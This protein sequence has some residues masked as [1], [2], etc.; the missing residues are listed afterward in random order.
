MDIDI[1]IP[2][3]NSKKTIKKTLHSIAS[4][5]II[6]KFHVYLVND[7]GSETYQE[8]I[9]FFRNMFDIVELMLPFN[10]GPGVARQYGI[11]HSDSKYIVF[12]DSDDYF[13]SSDSLSTMYNKICFE[14]SDLLISNFIYERDDE[15]LIKKKNPVWLHGKMYNREFLQKND[16]RFNDTRANEDNG[17]NRLVFL[18]GA[19]ISILDKVTYVYSENS[20]SITR[21]DD[22]EYR[23]SGLEGYSYNMAWAMNEAIKRDVDFKLVYNFSANVLVSMYFYYLDLY[24]QYDVSKII[25]WSRPIKKIYIKYCNDANA[26]IDNLIK[27]YKEV[28]YKNKDINYVISF[29]KFLSLIGDEF[30][31]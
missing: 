26:D 11:D 27:K 22:R 30:D 13:Y 23:F 2:A 7:C 14:D 29:E 9:N 3:Y 8:E 18:C 17:F 25:E 1:I 20:S 15:I 16:I 21:K 19:K 6:D 24:S 12:I 10:G 31:D 4:Q 5:N 28:E